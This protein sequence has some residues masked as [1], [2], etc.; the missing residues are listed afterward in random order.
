MNKDSHK[1][2]YSE[3]LDQRALEELAL[4]IYPREKEGAALQHAAGCSRCGPA[5]RRYLKI[6]SYEPLTGEEVAILDELETSKPERQQE[7][8][9]EHAL[10]RRS[11]HL[12]TRQT[13]N[14][15]PPAP[16]QPFWPWKRAVA[17]AGALG[18]LAIVFATWPAITAKIE[19]NNA[20]KKLAAA[21]TECRSTE[22]R[23][24]GVPY[25]PGCPQPKIQG[26]ASSEP[27]YKRPALL[28]ADAA[29]SR[30]L[31]SGDPRW[32]QLEGRVLLLRATPKSIEEAESLFKTA[33][34]KGLGDPSLQ[35]DL[36]NAYFARELDAHPDH[37]NL[38]Q[39]I[40]LLN[41]VVHDQKL[42]PNETAVALF[43]LAIAYEKT[44]AWDIAVQSWEEYL[45]QDP[46][47]PWADQARQHRDDARSKIPAPK[48][49]DPG[50]P[51]SF[52]ERFF[53]EDLRPEDPEWFQRQAVASWLPH[54][55]ED[56][57]SNFYLAAS[58]LAYELKKKLPIC[59]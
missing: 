33:Q 59:G 16:P 38:Q 29:I 58:K 54:A 2:L 53:R 31:K 24:P 27:E 12:N 11:A 19:F 10:N 51:E 17:L 40:D 50:S 22:V 20:Q 15:G 9:R 1:D 23:F 46:S 45:R 30:N 43:D 32:L 21:W 26:G 4:G 52:L 39:T 28:E 56:R 8:L 41:R 5:V 49:Q 48:Q 25:A 7:W 37:P 42:S 55:L 3:C 14:Q 18:A 13:A 36:A 57:N 35:I 44:N 47:G 34:A 6:F